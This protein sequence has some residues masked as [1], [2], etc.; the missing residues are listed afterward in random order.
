MAFFLLQLQRRVTARRK[1][2]RQVTINPPFVFYAP[3]GFTQQAE[4]LELVRLG[5]VAPLGEPIHARFAEREA[6]L[7]LI[8]RPNGDPALELVRQ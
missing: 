4:H 6:K 2:V 8:V 3:F 1:K 7:A 5:P